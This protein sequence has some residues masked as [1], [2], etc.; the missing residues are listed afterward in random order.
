MRCHDIECLELQLVGTKHTAGI[1]GCETENASLK[2][3]PHGLVGLV[4]PDKLCFA[5]VPLQAGCGN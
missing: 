2:V 5:P 3:A 4:V 1:S